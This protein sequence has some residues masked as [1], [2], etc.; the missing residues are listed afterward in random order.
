MLL[1]PNCFKRQC[2]NLQGIKQSDGGETTEI[3]FCKAF[4]TGIPVEISYGSN[5][6]SEVHPEQY[7]KNA[8]VYQKGKME[9]R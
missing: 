1:I 9:G 4:P 6:H 8:I 7:G 5:L 3:P 2:R